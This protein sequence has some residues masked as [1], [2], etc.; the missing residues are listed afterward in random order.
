MKDTAMEIVC[1]KDCKHL[2]DG[3]STY[4]KNGDEYKTYLVCNLYNIHV[5]A[6]HFCSDSARKQALHKDTPDVFER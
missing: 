3:R 1:C 5:E 2:A 6:D 4:I